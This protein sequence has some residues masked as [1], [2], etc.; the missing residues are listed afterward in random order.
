MTSVAGDWA[1]ADL[2]GEPCMTSQTETKRERTDEFA[3]CQTEEP[4]GRERGFG[5][6]LGGQTMGRRLDS[7]LRARVSLICSA[8]SLFGALQFPVHNNREWRPNPLL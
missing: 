3:C 5:I 2:R 4:P 8:F 6:G 7:L 1:K